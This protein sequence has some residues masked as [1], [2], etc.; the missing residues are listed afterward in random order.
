MSDTVKEFMQKTPTTYP[1]GRESLPEKLLKTLDV[2]RSDAVAA[3]A[4]RNLLKS[5]LETMNAVPSGRRALEV[6][7]KEGYSLAFDVMCGGVAA[8]LPESRAVLLNPS[9]ADDLPAALVHEARHA[10][11]Y[12]RFPA[13]ETRQLYVADLFKSQRAFEA[14]ACAHQCSF[15][16]ELKEARPEALANAKKILPMQENYDRTLEASGDKG[17]ALN[18]AFESWYDYDAFQQIYDMHHSSMIYYTV[19]EGASK[20]DSSFFS[21]ERPSGDIEKFCSHE[22]KSYAPA[23]FLDSPKA[24]SLPE[25]GKMEIDEYLNIYAASTGTKKDMSLNWMYTQV[26][27]EDASIRYEAPMLRRPEPAPPHRAFIRNT[28]E[29]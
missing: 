1:C 11:Q 22:G 3:E 9:L 18:A 2:S 25:Y 23:S 8:C 14:D 21:R 20:Q 6:L 13:E 19:M 17:K 27:N 28:V 29:R 10:E 15:V 7:D 12:A 26:R 5:V 4:D 24:F 16:H